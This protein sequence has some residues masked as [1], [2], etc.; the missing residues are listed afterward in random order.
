M[1]Q[2]ICQSINLSINQSICQSINQ[3]VNQ[4]IQSINVLC[5]LAADLLVDQ[6]AGVDH[7]ARHQLLQGVPALLMRGRR[8]EEEIRQVHD[9]RRPPIPHGH[10]HRYPRGRPNDPSSPHGRPDAPA[11][12]PG[13]PASTPVS[14]PVRAAHASVRGAT[15]PSV[16]HGW[17][18]LRARLQ[19]SATFTTILARLIYF[20]SVYFIREV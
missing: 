16:A 11:L 1:N 5:S 12:P 6:R 10:P 13:P 18:S 2:S 14:S 17:A 3:S 19:L 4:S 15:Q 7:P 8:G 20:R 9:H